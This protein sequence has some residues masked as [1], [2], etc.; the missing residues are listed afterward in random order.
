ME[1]EKVYEPQRFEPHWAKWWVDQGLFHPE[2]SPGDPYFSLVV[3][4]YRSG[5]SIIPFIE[6]LRQALSRCAFVSEIVLV[7][8]YLEG[9]DD[10]TP[11]VVT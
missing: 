1:I 8:N 7:G 2:P 6:K 10:R 5:T 3:L 4:C 11:E 9:S